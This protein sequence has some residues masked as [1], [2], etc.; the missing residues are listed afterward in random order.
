M[1]TTK[2]FHNYS[3]AFVNAILHSWKKRRHDFQHIIYRTFGTSVVL[4]MPACPDRIRIR[5][6]IMK[7]FL[8][9][10]NNCGFI[11]TAVIAVYFKTAVGRVQGNRIHKGWLTI[12]FSFK[13]GRPIPWQ[14]N[15]R[16]QYMLSFTFYCLIYS[17]IFYCALSNTKTPCRARLLTVG[18]CYHVICNAVVVV[19]WLQFCANSDFWLFFSELHSLKFTILLRIFKREVTSVRFLIV[20]G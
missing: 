18:V 9:S 10:Q 13:L 17:V 11:K 8:F 2:T 19:T 6:H 16:N 7:W 3:C 5:A 14:L 15:T 4:K 20:A 1:G 12:K